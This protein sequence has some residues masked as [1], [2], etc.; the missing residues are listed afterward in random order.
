MVSLLD[1]L[2]AGALLLNSTNEE[3]GM[4]ERCWNGYSCT[5]A[6]IQEGSI[7]LE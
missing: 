7:R 1:R 3:A 2:D 5:V 4:S 6:N